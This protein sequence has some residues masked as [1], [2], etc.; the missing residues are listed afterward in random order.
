MHQGGH[1]GSN[2]GPM[3]VVAMYNVPDGIKDLAGSVEVIVADMQLE[4]AHL[5]VEG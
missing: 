3:V 2:G 5:T 4:V 1:E